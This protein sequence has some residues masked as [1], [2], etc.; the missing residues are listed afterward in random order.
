MPLYEYYC[1]KCERT[2]EL[3]QKVGV[4]TTIQCESCTGLAERV[5]S[6][7][8]TTIKTQSEDRANKI[9]PLGLRNVKDPAQREKII[10]KENLRQLS[11]D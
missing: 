10:A 4:P 8:S 2:Y 6:A 1:E 9:D 5:V 11:S 7:F 3:L